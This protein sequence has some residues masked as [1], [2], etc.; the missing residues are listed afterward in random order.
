MKWLVHPSE[1]PIRKVEVGLKN[2]IA[3]KFLVHV[4]AAG[5]RTTF[6]E[7]QT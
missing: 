7:S 6:Q 5:P 4:D 1:L 2:C 3:N